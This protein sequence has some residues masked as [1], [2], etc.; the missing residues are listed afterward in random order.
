MR[1][2]HLLVLVSMM[3]FQLQPSWAAKRSTGIIW[4]ASTNRQT[5]LGA[6]I[7]DQGDRIFT[8][9]GYQPA[10]AGLFDA[11]G[12]GRPLWLH[13]IQPYI[14]DGDFS[15]SEDGSIKVLVYTDLTD[16][17]TGIYKWSGDNPEPD[18]H[19]RFPGRQIFAHGSISADGSKIVA[20][21]SSVLVLHTVVFDPA[22]AVPLWSKNDGLGNI[23]AVAVSGDGNVAIANDMGRSWAF[24]THNGKRLWEGEGAVARGYDLSW[25]GTH[26]V[27]TI[28][29][30]R[31]IIE[32]RRWNGTEYELL[33]NFAMPNASDSFSD[34]VAISD[35]GSTVLLGLTDWDQRG[36]NWVGLFD[37]SSPVPL[38]SRE[39]EGGSDGGLLILDVISGCD[40]SAD[41]SRAI[42][43]YWGDPDYPHEELFVFERESSDPIFVLDTP[44][45]IFGCDITSDGTQAA[46]ACKRLHAS[47]SG[48]GGT[49]YSIDL[50]TGADL[51]VTDSPAAPLPG[52]GN[53]TFSIK[54]ENT[55]SAAQE[56]DEVE[57]RV[58]GPASKEVDLY[59]GPHQWIAP[60]ATLENKF[61]LPLPELTPSGNYEGE[62]VVRLNG[63]WLDRASFTFEVQ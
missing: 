49:V 40:L 57:F 24:A 60:G 56:F 39:I 28:G 31:A 48:H 5:P 38:W 10:T 37:T 18:W 34:A 29:D 30:A 27:A 61:V 17:T 52:G 46:V 1:T 3:A 12:S 8:A 22:S 7:S 23:E 59:P 16:L 51:S 25:D 54:L 19:Y 47:R 21:S 62:V 14:I 50:T 33:W 44:G 32:V 36:H 35:D 63:G 26:I 9:V 4:E 58:S 6:S 15:M 13:G 43:G 2:K 42:V 11:W 45:S 20:I 53:L 55:G 41:G